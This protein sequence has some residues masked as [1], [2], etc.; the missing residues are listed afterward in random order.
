MDKIIRAKDYMQRMKVNSMREYIGKTMA[1]MRTKNIPYDTPFNN[2]KPSGKAV[3]AE[4]DFGQWLVKCPDPACNGAE[5]TDPS[6]EPIFYCFSC[7]NFKNNGK[8]YL[9]EFPDQ[10]T[11]EE[12]ERILLERPIKQGAAPSYIERNT[13][14][15]PTKYIEENG[16]FY[17]LSRSW[18]PGETVD[19][20]KKQNKAGK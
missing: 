17:P 14:A 11:C 5:T 18:T 3:K 10:K 20:L 2:D 1:G 9:V 4:I 12:I 15:H 8:P 13:P 7:G 6:E 19:D 16:K